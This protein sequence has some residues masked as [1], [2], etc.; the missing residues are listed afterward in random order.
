MESI[1]RSTLCDIDHQEWGI[2]S[3][4]CII[5]GWLGWVLALIGHCIFWQQKSSALH[6]SPYFSS[7]LLSCQS[8]QRPYL[9]QEKITVL[10]IIVPFMY[11]LMFE[12]YRHYRHSKRTPFWI[13]QFRNHQIKNHGKIKWDSGLISLPITNL[14]R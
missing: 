4:K 13:N 3:S 6:P 14:Y 5:I 9:R 11:P 2:H 8:I 1:G 10:I 12:H 7:I